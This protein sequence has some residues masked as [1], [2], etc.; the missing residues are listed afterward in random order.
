MALKIADTIRTNMVTQITNAIDADAG[1]GTIKIYDGVQPAK[2]GAATN[3]LAE[4]TFAT[5]ST[6]GIT[7]GVATFAAITQDASANASGDATWFRM[8]DESGDFVADG[9]VDDTGSPD[10]LLT[11]VTIVATQPV[12]IDTGGTITAGNN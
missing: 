11:T 5:T 2:G 8:A 10:L 7:G 12:S 6:S 9:T 1:G 4:L 3:L